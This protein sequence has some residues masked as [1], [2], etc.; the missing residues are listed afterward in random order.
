MFYLVDGIFN[1]AFPFLFQMSYMSTEHRHLIASAIRKKREISQIGNF[2]GEETPT[3]QA[4]KMYLDKRGDSKQIGS[5]T[6]EKENVPKK[7]IRK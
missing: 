7:Q 3:K 2:I 4:Q 5:Q 6:T 1:L